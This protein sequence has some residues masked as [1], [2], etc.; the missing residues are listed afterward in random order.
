VP[1]PDRPLGDITAEIK[2]SILRPKP[3]GERV[4]FK[5]PILVDEELW[6][7]ANQVITKR[8]RGRGKRGVSIQ[9]LLRNRI[10]CPRCLKPMVVRSNGTRVYYCCSNHSRPW[11][12]RPCDYGKFIPATWDDLIW[13]DVCSILRGDAWV[14]Q[15]LTTIES[16]SENR[17]KLVR[18]QQFKIAQAEARISK[19]QEG[20]E[21][22]LYTLDEAK[23]RIER[24]Q[25]TIARAEQE[26][27]R[28]HDEDRPDHRSGD[29]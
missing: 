11:A 4:H 26:I 15:Q 12:P 5:I 25:E 19:V 3:E 23:T 29:A 20:F 21:G 10:F 7:R 28:L 18:L 9:A 13:Q 22:H 6:L 2:R 17:E 24:H 27:R 14:E 1:N 16:Q 8:G